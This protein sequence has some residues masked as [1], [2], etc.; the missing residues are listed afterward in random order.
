[1]KYLIKDENGEKMRVV[2]RR[3]EAKRIVNIRQGWFFQK[4]P[5]EKLDLSKFQ[6]ALL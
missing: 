5:K 3:E 1:M 2:G 4:L 6:D